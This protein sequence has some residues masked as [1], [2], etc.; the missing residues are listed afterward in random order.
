MP[1]K[2]NQQSLGDALRNFI[3]D[4]HLQG[5]LDQVQAEETWM[6]VMGPGV[7]KYTRKVQLKGSTLHVYLTSSV[8][9]EELSLGTTNIIQM[10]N[11]AL[12]RELVEQ[13]RLQ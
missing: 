2:E 8:L 12:G 7:A 9:R 4:H 10:M 11:D 6:E 1:K 5:G 13:L 3:T